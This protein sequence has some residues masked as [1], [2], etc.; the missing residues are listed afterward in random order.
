MKKL[1]MS[2]TGSYSAR[3]GTI[4]GDPW[5]KK[6]ASV[7]VLKDR[8]S[9]NRWPLFWLQHALIILF[10][11]ISVQCGVP[12]LVYNLFRPIQFIVTCMTCVSATLDFL[13]VLAPYGVEHF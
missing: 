12:D 9:P 5:W 11:T 13:Y 8:V 2:A 10:L 6:S 1:K 3:P 4:S 7:M